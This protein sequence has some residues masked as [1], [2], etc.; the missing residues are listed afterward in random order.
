LG[1]WP[2]LLRAPPLAK[3]PRLCRFGSSGLFLLSR[4]KRFLYG[5]GMTAMPV[6]PPT[7]ADERATLE[8]FLDQARASVRGRCEGL[9]ACAPVAPADRRQS[10]VVAP[11]LTPAQVVSH[12]GRLEAR[13]FEGALRGEKIRG[14]VIGSADPGILALLLDEYDDQCQRSREICRTLSLDTAV[15]DEGVRF[16][17]RWILFHVLAETERH[18]GQLDALFSQLNAA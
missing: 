13:W 15:Y 11:D 16:S 7:V 12:L 8:A 14:S 5:A 4:R 18:L 9:I 17:V 2:A 10:D 6:A 1:W 3:V